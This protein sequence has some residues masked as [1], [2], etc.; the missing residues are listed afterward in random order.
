MSA[1]PKWFYPFERS[2]QK[3]FWSGYTSHRMHFFNNDS[4]VPD[5]QFGEEFLVTTRKLTLDTP[6]IHDGACNYFLFLGSD[7][8]DIFHPGIDVDFCIGDTAESMEIY[9]IDKPTVVMVPPGVFHAPLY[10]KDVGRSATTLLHYI[11]TTV[12]RVYPRTGANGKEEWYYAKPTG[13][14]RPCREN[15]EKECT[16]C[17]KCFTNADET[18]EDIE[19]YMAPFYANASKAEKYKNCFLELQPE[20]H[21]LGDAVI[22]PRLVFRGKK[23][24]AY[25]DEQFSFNIITAPCTLGDPVPVSNGQ[26]AEFLWFSGADT[27]DP[28]ASFEAEV[29]IMLGDDPD[30]MHPITFDEPGVIVLPPGSWRGEIKVKSVGKPLCFIP[31]YPYGKDRYKLT[32]ATVDGK[33]RL[34]FDNE[35]TI[36]E[37]T[38]GDELFLQI[39]R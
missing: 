14:R 13:E 24:I 21:K 10:Y 26:A 7:L 16:I 37:P 9:H 8:T 30:N 3:A 28:W 20:Y 4:I 5:V 19:N 11:G 35:T 18:E 23:D 38:A 36:T 31:F 32:Q 27:I 33:K 34:I 22:N 12:G 29:E 25:A 15:P 1:N 2:D 6:H 39:K 17:G